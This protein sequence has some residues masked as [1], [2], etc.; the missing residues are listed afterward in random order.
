MID[1]LDSIKNFAPFNIN[2]E[3]KVKLTQKG[4]D[5]YENYYSRFGTENNGPR[6][7]ENGYT[8]FQLWT[9]MKIYGGH[10][11]MGS[12]EEPFETTI[13]ISQPTVIEDD[14]KYHFKLISYPK[15]MNGAVYLAEFDGDGPRLAIK[16]AEI[17]VSPRYWKTRFTIAEAKKMLGSDIKLFKVVPIQ[18]SKLYPLKEVNQ[19]YNLETTH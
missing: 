4:I 8:G 2:E 11:F 7:D 5:I 1:M 18:E 12:L 16:D 13:F 3:V 10:L 14:K 6:I 19:G 17:T 9:L 15:L